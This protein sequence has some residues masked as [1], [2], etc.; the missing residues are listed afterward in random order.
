[1]DVNTGPDEI[2][3]KEMPLLEHLA[4]LRRRL[5]WS[6]VAF[7]LAFFVCYHFAP[8]IYDFLAAPLAHALEARGFL[9]RRFCRFPW[10]RRNYGCSSHPGCT[11]R[12]NGRCCRFWW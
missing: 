5:L 2:N 3:D 12:K 1:M 7:L 8:R 10:W 4:E 11:A 9:A 6:A